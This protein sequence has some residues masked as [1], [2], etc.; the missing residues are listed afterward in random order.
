MRDLR[1][2]AS[3]GLLALLV[4][5]NVSC[6]APPQQPR[7]PAAETQVAQ[8]F[9]VARRAY[10]QGDFT[11]AQALYRQ[12]LRRARAIDHAA[13]AADAAYNLAVSEIALQNYG[14]ADQ[15]LREAGFDAARASSDT[16]EPLLLRAKVAYLRGRPS[17]AIVLANEV[18]GS[19]AAPALRQQALLLR[20]Q[21]H[22][23]GGN[24]AAARTDLRAVIPQNAAPGATLRP[25][26]AADAKKL[27]GTIAQRSGEN[28][29]AA[30]LYDA[31]A[32]LLRAALRYRDMARAL[33]RAADA[34]LMAGSAA[35]A[36]ERFFL[37]ARSLD[38]LGDTAAAKG[39]LESSLAAAARTGDEG[40]R[41]RA[42]ALLDEI[43]RRAVP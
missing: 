39:Y 16:V 18:I 13:L 40:A 37:A 4:G 20:G 2:I 33:A 3:R 7:A 24:L 9:V 36:A 43:S 26:L 25:A 23:E 30:Q 29:V 17:E 28:I 22:A 8:T 35:L 11:Q 5:L 38:G 1:G 19:G 41:T 21:I 42:Q 31:E 32:E 12:A 15:L 14:A 34:H 6:V 10:E 27:E